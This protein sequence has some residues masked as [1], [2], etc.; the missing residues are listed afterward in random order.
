[1]ARSLVSA[2]VP[3]GPSSG[4]G[5]IPPEK[6][7]LISCRDGTDLATNILKH[8]R[9]PQ[10]EGPSVLLSRELIKSPVLC[11]DGERDLGIR[12]NL[13]ISCYLY[14][15]PLKYLI[16]LIPALLGESRVYIG[17]VDG[18]ACCH[19]GRL[20]SPSW[21]VLLLSNFQKFLLWSA[22]CCPHS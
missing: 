14:S 22:S 21:L 17:V 13:C 9:Y 5:Q 1:M 20:L 2:S 4:S 16:L 11:Q 19:I 3:L 7:I 15:Y 18:F 6:S 10:G 8:A 12:T